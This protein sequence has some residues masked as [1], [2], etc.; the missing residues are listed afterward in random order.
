MAE[1]RNPCDGSGKSP[2][3]RTVDCPQ[4][5]HSFPVQFQWPFPR[6]SPQRMLIVLILIGAT[7]RI[8]KTHRILAKKFRNVSHCK[9]SQLCNVYQKF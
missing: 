7:T 9:T 5:E 6:P 2:A 1:G 3:G 8:L 4:W